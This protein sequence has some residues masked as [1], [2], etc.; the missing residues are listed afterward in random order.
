MSLKWKPDSKTSARADFNMYTASL[1][2]ASG[3]SITVYL[4]CM[5]Y[6][7]ENMP[8]FGKKSGENRLF[9]RDMRFLVLPV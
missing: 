1:E 9:T 6:G 8:T 3:E 2:A 4:A 7:I 5:L